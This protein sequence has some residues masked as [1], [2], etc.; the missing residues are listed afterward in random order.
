MTHIWAMYGSC[1]SHTWFLW[2]I[3]GSYWSC[4]GHIGHALAILVIHLLYKSCM[5]HVWVKHGSDWSCTG[6]EYV[7]LVIRGSCMC[8]M[9]QACVIYMGYNSSC[10][11]HVWVIHVTHGS[12]MCHVWVNIG[13]YTD[14]ICRV[15]VILVMN[16]SC[17]CH[18]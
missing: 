6:H 9:G 7:I 15:W 5:N 8:H 17:M 11:G 3:H 13:S 1:R 12:C 4:V 16:G 2:V 14:D 18:V 10:M